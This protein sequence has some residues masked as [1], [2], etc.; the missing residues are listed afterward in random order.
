M[1]LKKDYETFYDGFCRDIQVTD[2]KVR[3]YR[4]RLSNACRASIHDENMGTISEDLSDSSGDFVLYTRNGIPSYHLASVLDDHH[5]G[6]TNVVRGLDLL[7]SSI[8]QAKLQEL[9]EYKTPTYLHL[10]IAKNKLGQKLSKQNKA[11][12]IDDKLATHTLIR[13]LGFLNQPNP[14]NLKYGTREEIIDWAVQNW[15]PNDIKV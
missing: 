2:Q 13:A 9:L 4:I 8:R 7:R 11:E 5:M 10:P 14:E 1:S 15:N 6:I 12:A 3:N